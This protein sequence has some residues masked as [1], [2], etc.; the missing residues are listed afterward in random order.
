ML[1]RRH[2]LCLLAVI[3]A[4]V[5]ACGNG[6]QTPA[7]TAPTTAPSSSTTATIDL[8]V[9]TAAGT[10]GAGATAPV[11]GT[12]SNLTGAC[13]DVTFVLADVTIHVTAATKFESGTCADIQ[14]GVRAGAIGQKN[15]KGIIEAARVK[16]GAA[17]PP[18]P[19]PPSPKPPAP[20]PVTGAVSGLTGSCPALTFT[21]S[22]TTVHTTDKTVFEGGT[23]ADV[24]EGARAG[25][26]GPK[27]ATG[28]ITAEHVKIAPPPPPAVSG[29]VTA[30]SGT[31]PA[32]T[33]TLSG[34]TVHTTDKTVFEG[35]T[36]AD[37]KEGA[38]AGAMGPKD[39]TGAITA[40]RVKIGPPPTPAV[41]GIVASTSGSCPAL[42]FV[43]SSPATT[44]AAATTTTVRVSDKTRVEGGTC[45]DIV[46]GVR[47]GATGPKATD[48]SIDAQVVK[49][50]PK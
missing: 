16:V 37:V 33:F 30:L 46:A 13:P 29:A 49:F 34:T 5:I 48:G 38:R 43:L 40:D 10:P 18:S 36:C 27:D 35:G 32:L 28:A 8:T 6:S 26:M 1:S 9:T 17:P 19:Q 47:I 45:A 31:C 4:F 15:D 2:S 23:C 3:A 12:V 11:V 7:P 39:A 22:G 21:L 14:N 20:P 41:T 50:G 25:A 42:T 24:K 44:G